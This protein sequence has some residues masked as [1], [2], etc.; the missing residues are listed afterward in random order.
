MGK[1]RSVTVVLAYL[2]STRPDLNLESALA[3]VREARPI[4]EPN[5]GFMAQLALYVTMKYHTDID[6][7]P[8]YQR[9]LY[10]REVELS[11]ATGRAPDTFRFEDE[12]AKLSLEDGGAEVQIHK[13]LRCKR[14]RRALA[15]SQYLIPHT[16]KAA[17]KSTAQDYSPISSLPAPNPTAAPSTLPKECTHHFIHPL[18]WMRLE[19]EKQLLEGRLNCPNSKCGSLVGRYAWQGM[20]CSCGIW[21]NPGFSLQGARVD[22][23]IKRASV[24]TASAGGI[25]M[26]PGAVSGIRLPPGL[27]APPSS[28]ATGPA[29]KGN[30]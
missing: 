29:E 13:E 16:P 28:S 10:D 8:I 20:R 9:W 21:V 23:I 5:D 14:C 17:N 22:E 6:S 7:H 3:L 1:S 11:V 25:R 4:A 26:P 19:L 24:T 2:L 30:L 15:T 27:K 18:S 12:V